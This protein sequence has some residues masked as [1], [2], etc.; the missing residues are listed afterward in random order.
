MAAR[1]DAS[2]FAAGACVFPGGRIDAGDGT[3]ARSADAGTAARVAAIR[4]TWEECGILLARKRDAAR[5]V[6][7]A[8]IDAMRARR[9][10]SF[11]R[12]IAGG[13][14]DIAIDL[15]VPF[16]HWITPQGRPKRYDTMFFLAPFDCDQTPRCDGQEAVEAFWARPADMIARAG[17]GAAKLVFATQM[18]L[19][20]LARAP[21]VEAAVR[22][23]RADRIVTVTPEIAETVRGTVFRIPIEAGYGVSE[24][25]AAGIP[26]A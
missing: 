12:L 10:E 3:L 1:N 25:P 24:V 5:L 21:N 18:N 2:G 11:A 9:G 8:E 26:R 16:A 22:A 14:L 20:K 17:R 4:E 15:L 6:R 19:I 23:A 13:A 7:A